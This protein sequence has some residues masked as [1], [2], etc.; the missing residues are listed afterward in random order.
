M[1]GEWSRHAPMTP[2]YAI[3]RGARHIR[4]GIFEHL[5]EPLR[6]VEVYSGN[7]R[8]LAATMAGRAGKWPL[9]KFEGQWL[10]LDLEEVTP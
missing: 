5:Y 6:I 4:D 7:K 10:L 1:K 3:F 8:E 2:C 9:S